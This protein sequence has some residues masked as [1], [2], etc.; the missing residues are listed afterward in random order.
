MTTAEVDE[1][2]TALDREVE[3]AFKFAQASPLPNEDEVLEYLYQ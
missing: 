3:E 2:A 1:L